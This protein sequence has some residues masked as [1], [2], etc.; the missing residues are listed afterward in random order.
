MT[1]IVFRKIISVLLLTLIVPA[2][3]AAPP[4]P[5]PDAGIGAL[6]V[7]TAPGATTPPVLVLYREPGVGRIAE[8]NVTSCPN[9]AFILKT[10][11]GEFPLVVTALKDGWMRVIYDDAGRAA[12]VDPSRRWNYLRWEEFLKGKEASLLRG[13]KKGFYVPRSGPDE[14]APELEPLTPERSL[15]IL[16]VAGD[17]IRVL[18]DLT[19]I[20]WLRWRDEDGRFLITL[21]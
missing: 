18:I 10:P 1:M 6:L 3:D 8:K 7:R 14:L 21:E 17:R 13:L 19:V 11:A 5:R 9:L 4:P 2:A 20:G 15:R 16:E 12:W